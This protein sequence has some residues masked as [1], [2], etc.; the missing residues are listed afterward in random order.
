MI[1]KWKAD[2]SL[3]LD[4]R[5]ISLVEVMIAMFVLMVVSLAVSSL[6]AKS[7][8]TMDLAKSYTEASTVAVQEL[9]QMISD[10]YAS[11]EPAGMSDGLVDGPHTKESADERYDI[12]YMILDD[13]ILPN[14][15]T[16][17][18]NVIFH[19]GNIEKS[20]RYNY[21]LPLRK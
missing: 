10:K 17:Q 13:D 1:R 7:W 18:M 12:S 21:L 20:V 4:D 11:S 5:G 9:E 19:R 2:C 14:T 8:K 15:K 3:H 6:T 16:V